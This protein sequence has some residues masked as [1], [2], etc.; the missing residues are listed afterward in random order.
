M[1]VDFN[2][3]IGKLDKSNLY[4]SIVRLPNQV[5]QA[6]DE[7]SSMKIYEKYINCQNI[8]ISGM[9]GSAL[10][11]RILNSSLEDKIRVPIDYS[12][13]QTLPNYI[14]SKSLVII[15]SY[16]GNTEETIKSLEVAIEKNANVFIITSGGILKDYIIKKNIPGY[17]INP[18]ENPCNQPRMGLGYSIFSMIA[19]LKK[20]KF[21][22]L[23][24]NDISRM[25]VLMKKKVLEFSK[26][27]SF[28]KNEAKL[29]ASK[30]KGKIPVLIASEHL[31][32]TA[33][34]FKNQLNENAKT[35]TCLFDIPEAN[36]H[37]MEGLRNPALAKEY[38]SFLFI[39]SKLYTP[40]CQK[41]YPLT[42]DVIEKNDIQT[43]S[44][45]LDSHSKLDQVA[46]LLVF[47]SFVSFYLAIL[48]DLDPTPIPW[49]DYFKEK[50]STL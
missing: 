15:S 17:I 34:A 40:F 12:T 50:L 8:L 41:R 30:L 10:G 27:I 44:Y 21:V 26:D 47:G 25:I 11:G 38:L 29:I 19:L 20:C 18:K 37:L 24:D 36:H 5:Q 9:G 3:K 46:E 43:I 32:G 22:N 28:E 48:Y 1:V 4:E 2:S 49:V 7:I 35:F 6:W 33:H 16:S 31:I 23:D 39:F 13:K 14:N 45:H 42:K